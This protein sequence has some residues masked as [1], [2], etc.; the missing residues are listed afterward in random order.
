MLVVRK[1]NKDDR[2]AI[3]RLIDDLELSHNALSCDE[4]WVGELNGEVV[5]IAQITPVGAS[6][7]LSSVGVRADHRR[8]GLAGTLL[9]RMLERVE[10]EVYLFTLEPSIFATM[11]FEP[12]SPP[13]GVERFRVHYECDACHAERCV[14]MKWNGGRREDGAEVIADT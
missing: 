13:E 7:V 14:C 8:R 2:A 11:G 4:F 5:A 6:H 9:D 3:D 10:G 1:S 12:A